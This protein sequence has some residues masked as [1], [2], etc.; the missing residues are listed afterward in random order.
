VARL[1]RQ[2]AGRCGFLR[3]ELRIAAPDSAGADARALFSHR[4]P[5]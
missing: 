4:I 1:V 2:E 5:A 3:F